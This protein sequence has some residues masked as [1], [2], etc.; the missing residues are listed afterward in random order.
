MGHRRASA[1]GAHLDDTFSGSVRQTS[2]KT[3][4]ETEAI[5]VVADALAVLQHHGVDRADAT[6]FR[7]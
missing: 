4:G 3:L 7:R 2:A 1:T 6:G 5:G